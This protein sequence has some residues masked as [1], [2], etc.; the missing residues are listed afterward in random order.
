MGCIVEQRIN[1]DD[2]LSGI[3]FARAGKWA[4]NS[5]QRNNEANNMNKAP[6]FFLTAIG[7]ARVVGGPPGPPTPLLLIFHGHAGAEIAFS[8]NAVVRESYPDIEQLQIVSVVDL[9]HIPRYMRAAVE[10]TL[11]A[12]YR[13]AAKR[14]PDN[15]DPTEYVVI[16][17]DWEGKVTSAYGMEDRMNDIGLVLVAKEWQIADRYSGPDPSAAAL[18]MLAAVNN[19]TADSTFETPT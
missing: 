13:Q 6:S 18:K 2:W 3:H 14:I 10:L 19:E 9:R 17:P 12:A 15:L 7:A 5:S 8:I 11:A 4:D 1:I 16:V